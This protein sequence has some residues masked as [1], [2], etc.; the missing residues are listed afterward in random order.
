MVKA[1][2]GG[3]GGMV[4]MGQ[5]HGELGQRRMNKHETGSAA[6]VTSPIPCLAGRGEGVHLSWSQT[7]FNQIMLTVPD[8][9]GDLGD[10]SKIKAIPQKYSK[11]RY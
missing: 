3:G 5:R 10:T 9:S 1:W 6:D 8:R 2:G 4:Q 7:S 11:D